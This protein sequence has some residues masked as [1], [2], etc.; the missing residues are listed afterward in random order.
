MKQ[1]LVIKVVETDTQDLI[2]KCQELTVYDAQYRI[3]WIVFDR[4]QVVDFDQIVTRAEKAGIYAGVVKS[5]L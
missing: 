2:Q 3:P 1:K 4:D 5:M